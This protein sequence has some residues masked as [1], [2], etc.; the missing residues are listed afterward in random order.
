MLPDRSATASTRRKPLFLLAIGALLLFMECGGQEAARRP[1][2][3]TVFAAASLTDAFGAIEQDFEA[4][5]PHVDIVLNLAGS[6]HLAQQ[7]R[8]GAPA[9]VFASANPAQMTVA[10]ESGRIAPEAP[11]PFVQNRLVLITPPSNPGR[12]E[13]LRDLARPD[14]RIVLA[15]AAVPAGRYARQMLE[16]ASQDSTFTSTFGQEVLGN[17]VSFEQNVRV[18]LTKVVLGEADAGIVYATD[19]HGEAADA[20]RVLDVPEPLNVAATYPIAPVRD[21]AHPDVAAAFVHFVRSASGRARLTDYGFF[22]TANPP[23]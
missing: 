10:V 19:P 9:D 3:L 11:E 16:A 17:V 18:V 22:P 23:S 2:T 1:V 21:S 15:D 4:Q 6:Q 12:V 14:V 5:H 8:L 13:G 7:L 20:V